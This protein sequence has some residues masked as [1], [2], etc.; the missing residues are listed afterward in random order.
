MKVMDFARTWS[1]EK[2]A[3]G[4]KEGLFFFFLLSDIASGASSVHSVPSRTHVCS[5]NAIVSAIH[6]TELSLV[7]SV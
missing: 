5:L 3:M 1:P 7:A 2:D 4:L 6:C